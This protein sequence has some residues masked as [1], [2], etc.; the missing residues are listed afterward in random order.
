MVHIY[1]RQQDKEDHF[2]KKKKTRQGRN[3]VHY[4]MLWPIFI[5]IY[6]YILQF[7]IEE[8]DLVVAISYN[9]KPV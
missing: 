2:K 3:S 4:A 5:D 7:A 1:R 9:L 8:S 6:I